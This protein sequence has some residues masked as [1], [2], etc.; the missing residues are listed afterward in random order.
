VGLGFKNPESKNMNTSETS[1]YFDTRAYK[2]SN[3]DSLRQD[4][5]ALTIENGDAPL[6]QRI[7][8][9]ELSFDAKG[10][11]T[12]KLRWETKTD[13][14]ENQALYAIRDLVKEGYTKTIWISPP[15]EEVGYTE[16]RMVVSVLKEK[17][18]DGSLLFECRGLCFKFGTEK[19]L[20]I[21]KDFTGF[22]FLN[23]EVLRGNPIVF[24]L[25][26]GDD[27]WVDTLER[28]IIDSKV[29]ETIRKGEDW[30]YKRKKEFVVDEVINVFG[31]RFKEEMS[32]RESLILGS[33][34]EYFLAARGSNMQQVGS[35]GVSNTEALKGVFDVVFDSS[36]SPGV[37]PEGY[38]YFC[39]VCHCWCKGEICNICKIKLSKVS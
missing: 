32:Y 9:Y 7:T 15:S 2:S 17:K 4:L 18:N 8:P 1:L 6:E 13:K 11:P 22:D 16:S 31:Q 28:K 25:E 12:F 29:W 24:E 5:A 14:L 34:I 39:P 33:E 36:L 26:D 20:E 19:C 21:A 3:E 38:N 37:K 35:C 10:E 30:I 27:S 23:G